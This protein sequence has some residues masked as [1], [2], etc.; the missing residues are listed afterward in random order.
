MPCHPTH[1]K[2]GRDTRSIQRQHHWAWG[3]DPQDPDAEEE[4]GWVY[5]KLEAGDTLPPDQRH[6]LGG[7]PESGM[8][9]QG[10]GEM[11]RI[12][13]SST[14]KAIV[15]QPEVELLNKETI[16]DQDWKRLE[17]TEVL[18]LACPKCNR[19]IQM[20]KQFVPRIRGAYP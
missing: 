6:L 10:C 20:L 9:C 18:I 15:E 7:G 2:T 12:A 3:H 16:T 1:K 14:A 13:G 19:L 17:Q 8:P 4:S 5:A 11:T